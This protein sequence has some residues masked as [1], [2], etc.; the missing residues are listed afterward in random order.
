M[1]L[2]PKQKIILTIGGVIVVIG[3][4]VFCF[5]RQEPQEEMAFV[6]ETNEIE[7]TESEKSVD[8]QEEKFTI[9]VH[10][11][12]EIK[13]PGIVELEEGSR[14]MDAINA[15]GGTTQDADVSELNLAYVLEDG[16]KIIVPSKEEVK[17]NAKQEY[18]SSDDGNTVSGNSKGKGKEEKI[19]VNINTAAQSELEMIPGIGPSTA[20]KIIEYRKE[21]GKFNSIED[22]KNVK[23][24]GDAKF[25]SMKEYIT[26]K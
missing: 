6:Q 17:E 16:E 14:I 9:I 4:V 25:N 21:N 12:G 7:E 2:N 18:I 1:E 15:A 10:I 5:L 26:V 20:L 23:G 8:K 13:V 11:T 3:I 19:M 22:I 24:I